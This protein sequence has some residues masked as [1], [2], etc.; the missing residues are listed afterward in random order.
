V[1]PLKLVI[2]FIVWGCECVNG[3]KHEFVA[4]GISPPTAAV[5]FV[6][7]CLA[8]Q[9]VCAWGSRTR[10]C[11]RTCMGNEYVHVI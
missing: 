1:C 7:R 2:G 4:D 6:A 11:T 10:R 3:A 5:M 9:N 8:W